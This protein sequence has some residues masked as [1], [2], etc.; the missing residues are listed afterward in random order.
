MGSY[1]IRKL[2]AANIRRLRLEHNETQEELSNVIGYSVPAVANYE[3][4]Y[5]TPDLE[6][7]IRIAKHYGASIEDFL[8][9]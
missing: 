8:K 7:F 5:R 3:K 2:V 9:E 1:S 4:G 6:T